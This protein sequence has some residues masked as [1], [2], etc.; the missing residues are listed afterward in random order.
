MK[1]AKDVK[2][3]AVRSHTTKHS[4]NHPRRWVV[5]RLAV[6]SRHHAFNVQC[7][8]FTL[9]FVDVLWC[10]AALSQSDLSAACASSAC[11]ALWSLT[12]APYNVYRTSFNFSFS[13]PFPQLPFASGFGSQQAS[14]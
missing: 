2:L 6:C 11:F 4:P 7:P 10:V 1:N 12:A 3:E 9:H 14:A 8:S 5:W 13:F